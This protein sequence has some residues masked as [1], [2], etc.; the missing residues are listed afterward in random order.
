MRHGDTLGMRKGS[1]QASVMRPYRHQTRMQHTGGSGG[2][3]M[4]G[5]GMLN[6]IGH[7]YQL[8]HTL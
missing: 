1:E 2:T 6:H 5:R 3:G 7:P 8:F 4:C